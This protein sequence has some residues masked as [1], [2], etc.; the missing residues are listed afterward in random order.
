MATIPGTNTANML[1]SV[2]GQPRNAGSPYVY[3]RRD[4]ET[5]A[6]NIGALG[7]GIGRLAIGLSGDARTKRN[8]DLTLALDFYK[9]LEGAR[10]DEISNGVNGQGWEKNADGTQ[11]MA[12]QQKS[13]EA[14]RAQYP[15]IDWDEFAKRRRIIDVSNDSRVRTATHIAVRKQ[16]LTANAIRMKDSVEGYQEKGDIDSL[17]DGL[18]D[19]VRYML[20]DDTENINA[21]TSAAHALYSQMANP[22]P[23]NNPHECLDLGSEGGFG[24]FVKLARTATELDIDGRKVRVVD[25]NAAKAHNGE[26]DVISRTDLLTQV[27]AYRQDYLNKRII[28]NADVG[29][30]VTAEVVKRV[31]TQCE[32]GDYDGARQTLA[33]AM[34]AAGRYEAN[35][36]V[37]QFER[38]GND[39]AVG[40]AQTKGAQNGMME[41]A[42]VARDT[43]GYVETESLSALQTR[44]SSLSMK[45]EGTSDATERN[46]LTGE[47][48]A[49]KKGEAD[50]DVQT[51]ALD[52]ANFDRCYQDLMGRLGNG[53]PPMAAVKAVLANE[54]ARRGYYK[55]I[56]D[57]GKEVSIVQTAAAVEAANMENARLKTEAE[58]IAGQR[59]QL[60]VEARARYDALG[61]HNAEQLARRAAET[62]AAMETLNA[63]YDKER[64]ALD[65]AKNAHDREVTKRHRGE[66]EKYADVFADPASFAA[67]RLR[68]AV[69]AELGNPPPNGVSL[70]LIQTYL[71]AHGEDPDSFDLRSIEDKKRLKELLAHDEEEAAKRPARGY[72]D[73]AGSLQAEARR[74]SN[75]IDG[76]RAL[77]LR[78]DK[79]TSHNDVQY[80]EATRALEQNREL[81][82]AAKRADINRKNA[83]TLD[84]DAM[85]L[86]A[87]GESLLAAVKAI[88]SRYHTPDVSVGIAAAE[89]GFKS[90]RDVA[91]DAIGNAICE[92]DGGEVV[93]AFTDGT[94]K[95]QSLKMPTREEADIRNICAIMQVTD[96]KEVARII[97]KVK[98]HGADI[99]LAEN[100]LHQLACK[101]DAYFTQCSPAELARFCPI[102]VRQL[103][104]E[105]SAARLTFKSS[106]DLNK[107]LSEFAQGT[108]MGRTGMMYK[109]GD[110]KRVVEGDYPRR[111][112]QWGIESTSEG[113]GGIYFTGVR[114]QKEYNNLFDAMKKSHKEL[115]KRSA[116]APLSLPAS[117]TL[118]LDA[119]EAGALFLQ[120][121]AFL[122]EFEAPSGKAAGAKA[123][124]QEKVLTYGK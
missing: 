11:W 60:A 26:A 30:R 110:T 82:I 76:I 2:I 113:M 70:P 45:L 4:T 103:A 62:T 97:D 65:E 35:F 40:E 101:Y 80:A 46:L 18:T 88:P 48:N 7:R 98:A 123:M 94:G 107:D 44:I 54:D 115:R 32:R 47:I 119:T 87:Q 109:K 64:D 117:V 105:I 86:T 55:A 12:G 111:T 108:L 43:R 118:G 59:T 120:N 116:G 27:N 21:Q 38:C 19:G 28:T 74:A 41:L 15:D 78:I 122:Y 57:M 100:A 72:S 52:A 50:I 68:Q 17:I 13:Y 114:Q 36:D 24:K 23:E 31:K 6:N 95:S 75:A 90:Q 63:K 77:R 104:D 51:K 81:E 89:D 3:E 79:E 102:L 92:A 20:D 33:T 91:I 56:F 96:Q 71:V 112:Y 61:R 53:E 8:N 84:V 66:I 85:H 5:L 69:I 22:D 10:F 14:T 42:K 29:N 58:A 39:I 83:T 67:S 9:T 49:L 25:D 93:M 34:E 1:P 99:R 106:A 124:N 37:A 121:G 73:T 16:G